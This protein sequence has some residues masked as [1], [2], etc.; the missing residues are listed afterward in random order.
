MSMFV[1]TGV[2][3]AYTLDILGEKNR[4]K[5][6][7]I[8]LWA[9]VSWGLGAMG[10]GFLND[11][12][13]GF[14]LNFALYGG[15]AITSIVITAIWI[16]SKTE[17]EAAVTADQVGCYLSNSHQSEAMSLFPFLHSLHPPLARS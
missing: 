5:Y 7:E 11:S 2:V 6:G 3:D 9:A 12:L 10:M 13:G 1:S 15:F 17:S 8:R 4:H 16:P 14:T